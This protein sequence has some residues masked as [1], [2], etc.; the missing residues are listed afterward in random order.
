MQR[1]KADNLQ[2]QTLRLNN[3]SLDGPICFYGVVFRVDST[4]PIYVNAGTG[5][6]KTQE[7]T[8][9]DAAT[10][11]NWFT[12]LGITDAINNAGMNDRGTRTAAE[13]EAD[14]R[15]LCGRFD[16]SVTQYIV[17]PNEPSSGIS[18]YD[19]VYPAVAA[20]FGILIDLQEHFGSYATVNAAGQMADTE[21]TNEHYQYYQ[22]EWYA[23][24]LFGGS[25]YQEN[26]PLIDYTAN[27]TQLLLEASLAAL[28][29]RIEALE[30]PP[31]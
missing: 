7:F 22:A 17:K 15:E 27:D 24:I 23:K 10:Q 4:G 20:D 25:Y 31:L 8:E 29:A 12:M 13:F 30:V 14:L 26:P 28:L 21:H 11:S 19:A 16:S 9:Y 6:Q 5:G 3:L 1:K 2:S 18:I